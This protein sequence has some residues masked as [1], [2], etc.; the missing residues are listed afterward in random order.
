LTIT[1]RSAA[2]A[3]RRG[4]SLVDYATIINLI[5]STTTSSGLKVYARLDETDYPKGVAVSDGE[6]AQVNI[7]H[8][9]FHGD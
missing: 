6:I 7:T 8:H 9:E 1:A 5:T 4:K 3:T 2:S